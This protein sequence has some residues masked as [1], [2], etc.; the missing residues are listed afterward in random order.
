MHTTTTTTYLLF[1]LLPATFLL[2]HRYIFFAVT[3]LQMTQHARRATARP[4]QRPSTQ[5]TQRVRPPRNEV[6][7]HGARVVLALVLQYP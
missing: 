2:H 6:L 3:T 5:L 7:P 1:G 4:L